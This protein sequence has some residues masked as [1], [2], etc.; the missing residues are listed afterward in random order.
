MAQLMRSLCD[1]KEL[2]SL[3]LEKCSSEI[4]SIVVVEKMV[5]IFEGLTHQF[6]VTKPNDNNIM[7]IFEEADTDTMVADL[8]EYLNEFSAIDKSRLEYI[9][10][11]GVPLSHRKDIYRHAVVI[12]K[13]LEI[14]CPQIL[15]VPDNSTEIGLNNAIRVTAFDKSIIDKDVPI[16]DYIVV[17]NKGRTRMIHLI[18]HEL[19]HCWQNYKSAGYYQNYRPN[20]NINPFDFAEQKEE[21]DAEAFASLYVEKHL[22]VS[23]GTAFMFDTPEI[24]RGWDG[25]VAK[26]KARMKEITL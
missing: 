9:V 22:G 3:V 26:V 15:A 6:F 17:R 4:P 18:A 24:P 20:V 8:R 13:M 10:G 14:V 11:L 19:R 25:Y 2:Y 21:I 7:L 5:D 12:S 16:G 1:V 23:D